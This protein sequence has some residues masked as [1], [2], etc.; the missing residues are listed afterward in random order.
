MVLATCSPN[1][2]SRNIVAPSTFSESIDAQLIIGRP[3]RPADQHAEDGPLLRTAEI[4][5]SAIVNRIQRPK[6]RNLVVRAASGML[7]TYRSDL[8]GVLEPDQHSTVT[9]ENVRTRAS[10]TGL[11]NSD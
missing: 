8:G 7:Q 10:G 1:P 11:R 3:A 2:C 9:A 4:R 5:G 6:T